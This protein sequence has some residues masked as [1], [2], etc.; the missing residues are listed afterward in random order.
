MNPTPSITDDADRS[1]LELRVDDDLAG[2]LDYRPGGP[3]I[4]IA[5]TEVDD[6]YAGQ[7]LGGV[8]VRHA[9]DKARSAD[10]TV[11]ATCPF[12]RSYIDRHPELEEFL[13]PSARRGGPPAD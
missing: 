5:H 12:A 6:R 4:I 13:V 2:W 1:R 3:S 11:I 7:G 10:R 9:I 8:L